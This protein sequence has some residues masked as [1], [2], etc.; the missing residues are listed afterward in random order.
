MNTDLPYVRHADDSFFDFQCRMNLRRDR[1]ERDKLEKERRNKAREWIAKDNVTRLA[2]AYA[3][4][5]A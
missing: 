4:R 3:G 1:M 5:R 2:D